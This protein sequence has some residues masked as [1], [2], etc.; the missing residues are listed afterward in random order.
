MGEYAVFVWSCYG[1]VI[2]L[3]TALAFISWKNKKTDEKKLNA[4][5]KQLEEMN[6]QD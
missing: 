1:A 5:S 2:V 3:M 4:L 6:K